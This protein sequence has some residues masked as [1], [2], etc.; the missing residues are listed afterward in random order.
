MKLETTLEERP[1]FLHAMP[2]FDL[3]M[4]VVMMLLLGPMFLSQSGVNVE[5]PVS[6]F[7]MQRYEKSVTV[8]LAPGAGEPSIHLGRHPVTKEELR[9]HLEEMKEDE[10]MAGAMVLLNTDAGVSVG[11]ERELAELILGVGYKVALVGRGREEEGE[12]VRDD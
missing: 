10:V 12:G 6:Q 4:L 2:V 3:L 5:V 1:G 8:T 7:Q 11:V 9:K